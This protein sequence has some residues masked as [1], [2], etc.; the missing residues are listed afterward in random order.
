M[1]ELLDAVPV[2][3]LARQSQDL[4]KRSALGVGTC[5]TLRVWIKGARAALVARLV[6][7]S[8]TDLYNAYGR[9]VLLS[10]KF[11]ADPHP[12]NLLVPRRVGRALVLSA[13][14]GAIPSPFRCLVPYAPPRLYLIDWGQAS[15]SLARL[16]PLCCCAPA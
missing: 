13:L 14:R 3:A 11:H 10:G 12:G 4:N 7:Q 5:G 1:T 9:M 8:L 16:R 6:T 2:S 15:E